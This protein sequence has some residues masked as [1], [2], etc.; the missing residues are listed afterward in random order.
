MHERNRSEIEAFCLNTGRGQGR[1]ASV[2]FYLRPKLYREN[3]LPDGLRLEDLVRELSSRNKLRYPPNPTG[4]AVMDW[5]LYNDTYGNPWTLTYAGQFWTSFSVAG[6]NELKI[7]DRDAGVSPLR[8][9]EGFTLASDDWIDSFALLR[10]L[11]E[12]FSFAAQLAEKFGSLEF[13]EWVVDA[14]GLE[15]KWLRFPAHNF[16]D[17]TGPALAPRIR[18]EK[19]SLAS[20]FANNWEF[21]AAKCT[22]AIFD[23]CC[24]DGREIEVEE[25]QAILAALNR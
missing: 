21:E 22:K 10:Q 16:A 18:R 23:A 6:H 2:T 20:D 25:I 3:R 24:R 5:G 19:S 12:C 1:A 17:S 9:S 11:K 15:K 7:S 8:L 4:N 14:Q 13:I